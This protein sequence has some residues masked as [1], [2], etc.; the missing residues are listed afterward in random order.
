MYKKPRSNS[1]VLLINLQG[2]TSTVPRNA[3]LLTCIISC[4]LSL[5]NIGSSVA[6]NA[7]IS[8]Q[9]MALMATYTISI[10]CV[11]YQ[12]TLGGGAQLPYA[13]WSLG[14]WGTP[15][16]A[17]AFVY[18][19]QVLFWTGW[20]GQG[21]PLLTL[22]NM[23]WSSVMFFGVMTISMVYYFIFGRTSYKGPVVLVRPGVNVPPRDGSL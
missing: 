10:G 12:R 4:L 17:I 19:A 1:Y 7:I 15:I 20:P 18:S 6:F 3:I 14:R 9:L 22:Q 2:K 16:N 11:L 21:M 23:N 13:R 5:I 8:L